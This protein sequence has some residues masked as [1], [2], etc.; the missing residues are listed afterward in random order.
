MAK[1]LVEKIKCCSFVVLDFLKCFLWER[2]WQLLTHLLSPSLAR[3]HRLK[4]RFGLFWL[5]DQVL[6]RRVARWMGKRQALYLKLGRLEKGAPFH[7]N[8]LFGFCLKIFQLA[9]S[10]V[11]RSQAHFNIFLS[12]NEIDFKRFLGI[13][14]IKDILRF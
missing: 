12:K 8:S 10:Q 4:M 11:F 6:A 1:C 14:I 2:C 9:V 3:A 5:K 7:S 13:V